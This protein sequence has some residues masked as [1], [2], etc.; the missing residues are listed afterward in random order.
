[1]SLNYDIDFSTALPEDQ[2]SAGETGDFLKETEL[3]ADQSQNKV[4]MFRNPETLAALRRAPEDVQKFMAEISMGMTVYDSGVPAGQF[5]KSDTPHR[6]VLL[7]KFRV[8]SLNPGVQTL[9]LRPIPDDEFSLLEFM[10]HNIAAS[11][12]PDKPSSAKLRRE[13][14]YSNA[15]FFIEVLIGLIVFVILFIFFT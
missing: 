1:M 10:D 7:E 4:A 8:G 11:P 12:A 15:K 14:N 3:K 5:P 2:F 13:N 9:L 6:Q